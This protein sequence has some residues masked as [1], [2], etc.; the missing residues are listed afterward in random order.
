MGFIHR[1]CE[2]TLA[3]MHT[4]NEI[5]SQ[6]VRVAQIIIFLAIALVVYYAMDRDPPFAVVSVLPAQARPGEYVTLQATVR[7][8]V[9]RRCSADFSRY[10]Y[11][12]AGSRFDLGRSSASAEMIDSLERTSPGFLKVSIKLPEVMEP[13][14]ADMQTVLAYRCNKVHTIWPI[15]VTTDI[16]FLVLP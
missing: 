5:V 1:I 2:G 10:L 13:G 15:E 11:D 4:A 7:R 16:P 6:T 14:Q 3:L 8:D 9:D 12:S